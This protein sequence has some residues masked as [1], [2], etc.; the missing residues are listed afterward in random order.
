MLPQLAMHA[1]FNTEVGRVILT[2][3]LGLIVL[4]FVA[5]G[6]FFVERRLQDEALSSFELVNTPTI[7]QMAL[8]LVAARHIA[9]ASGDPQEAGQ[10]ARVWIA[11]KSAGYTGSP[12][13]FGEFACGVAGYAQSYSLD[14]DSAIVA[15]GDEV[16]DEGWGSILLNAV[17]ENVPKIW[18][19]DPFAEQHLLIQRVSERV[20]DVRWT[21]LPPC[22][23]PQ[24]VRPTWPNGSDGAPVPP[25]GVICAWPDLSY[26][27]WFTRYGLEPDARVDVVFHAALSDSEMCPNFDALGTEAWDPRWL[28]VESWSLD[29]NPDALLPLIPP[30]LRQP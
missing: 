3:G 18:E 12:E 22:L 15:W 8:L 19:A 14:L 30:E 16:G 24:G 10:P 17:N 20:C 21:G 11:A 29:H 1:L 23:H 7:G 25:V 5:M 13:E 2:I 28:L 6:T 26:A 4:L 27:D 9:V